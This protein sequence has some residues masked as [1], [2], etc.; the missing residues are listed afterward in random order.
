VNGISTSGK[1][2]LLRINTSGKHEHDFVRFRT[3]NPTESV[4]NPTPRFGEPGLYFEQRQ[5]IE[6]SS[7]RAMSTV[8]V[9]CPT[10]GKSFSAGIET[11]RATFHCLRDSLARSRCRA[12]IKKSKNQTVRDRLRGWACEIRTAESVRELSF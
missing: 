6:A 9:R 3:E 7:A 10:T 4:G 5:P 12:E 11:D 1:L 8:M 2:G